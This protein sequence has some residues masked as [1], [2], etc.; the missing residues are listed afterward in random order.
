[1]ALADL[2]QFIFSFIYVSL[3]IMM[4]RIRLLIATRAV[5]IW[6]PDTADKIMK[7]EILF[8]SRQVIRQPCVQHRRMLAKIACYIEMSILF[9]LAFN[10]HG[11]CAYF[12]LL[13]RNHLQETRPHAFPA[14]RQHTLK[15][16]SHQ[17]TQCMPFLVIFLYSCT[18][19]RFSCDSNNHAAGISTHLA[20]FAKVL[21]SAR[22]ANKRAY[23]P[24]LAEHLSKH[25]VL[26]SAHVDNE[27]THA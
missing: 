17:E 15:S 13:Y 20:F 9:K 6:S 11:L 1:M 4:K 27:R 19:D 24:K 25:T 16:N 10:I 22:V 12:F 3:L 21:I 18:F 23:V 2:P 14:L 5:S 7:I 8:G 26:I